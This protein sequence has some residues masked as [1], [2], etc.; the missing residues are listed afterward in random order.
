MLF[1]NGI[2]PTLVF[3]QQL[4]FTA[5][6]DIIFPPEPYKGLFPTHTQ[7]GNNKWVK[8]TGGT[9]AYGMAAMCLE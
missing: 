6:A 3:L 7:M 4:H 9:F 8:K 1:W 2:K 5:E